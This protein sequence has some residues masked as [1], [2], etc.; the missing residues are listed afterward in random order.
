MEI[1]LRKRVIIGYCDISCAGVR[2]LLSTSDKAIDSGQPLDIGIDNLHSAFGT[3]PPLLVYHLKKFSCIVVNSNIPSELIATVTSKLVL[4]LSQHQ[5]QEVIIPTALQFETGPKKA[6]P[7][8]F[9]QI[10]EIDDNLIPKFDPHR[11][12]NDEFLLYLVHFLTIDEIP[13]QIIISKGNKYLP[14]N[15]TNTKPVVKN[16]GD[17]VKSHVDDISYD[18]ELLPLLKPNKAAFVKQEPRALIYV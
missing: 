17:V 11:P 2:L 18:S 8:Y 1:C 14:N 13:T 3:I 4:Y 5:V 15:P 6:S 10:P 7:I 9:V 12:I 16:L